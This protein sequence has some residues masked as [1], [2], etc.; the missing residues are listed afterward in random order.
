M[1]HSQKN[2]FKI[3]FPKTLND[4]EHRVFQE[5]KKINVSTIKNLY[6]SIPRRIK[7]IYDQ[8]GGVIKY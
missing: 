7:L 6:N 5:W 1:V 3:P 4:L 8:K 2:V